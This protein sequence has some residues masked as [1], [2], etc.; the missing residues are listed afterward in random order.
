MDLTLFFIS[1][2][3]NAF[4][5]IKY[6][7]KAYQ[8]REFTGLITQDPK[9]NI[10][11]VPNEN[12]IGNIVWNTAFAGVCYGNLI[13]AFPIGKTH[14]WISEN[15]ST[16]SSFRISRNTENN[17]VIVTKENGIHKNGLM[18]GTPI[19]IIVYK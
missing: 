6:C 16:E 14:V 9:G 5:W 8:F 13:D 12:T 7:R 3:L 4:F 10:T 11:I 19:R 15:G 1:I 17:I 18:V 2:I